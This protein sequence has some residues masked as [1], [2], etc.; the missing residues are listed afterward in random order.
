MIDG[1]ETRWRFNQEHDSYA[2]DGDGFLFYGGALKATP[3]GDLDGVT[4]PE[5]KGLPGKAKIFT[6]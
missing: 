6:R 3:T 4:N 2:K 5:K 1:K